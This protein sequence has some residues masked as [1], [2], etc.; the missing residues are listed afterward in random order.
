MTV[1]VGRDPCLR[2]AVAATNVQSG[3]PY[4]LGD[5]FALDGAVVHLSHRVLERSD[6]HALYVAGDGYEHETTAVEI[7]EQPIDC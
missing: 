2:P 5:Y 6:V 4:V 7:R 1:P 3:V